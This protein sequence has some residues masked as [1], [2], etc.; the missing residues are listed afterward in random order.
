MSDKQ[1]LYLG[2]TVACLLV[3]LVLVADA[4]P[5][6][7]VRGERLERHALAGGDVG[8][9]SAVRSGSGEKCER[10]PHVMP[11]MWWRPTSCIGVIPV[12]LVPN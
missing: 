2:T 1:A 3:R 7:G 5:A 9:R 12:N 8:H 10:A 4:V 11:D 6:L